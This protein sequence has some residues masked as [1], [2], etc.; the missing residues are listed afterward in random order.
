MVDVLG[1][2]LRPPHCK[3]PAAAKA[4]KNKKNGFLQEQRKNS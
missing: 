3:T 4:N 2:V 1:D